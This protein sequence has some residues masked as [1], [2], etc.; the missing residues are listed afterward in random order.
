[1]D[2]RDAVLNLLDPGTTPAHTPAAFFMH[3]GPAYREGPAAIAKHL[4]Y[5]RHTGM[6]FVKI[7]YEHVFPEIAQIKT[8]ADWCKMPVYDASFYAAPLE[9]AKGLVAAVKGEAL[10]LM[11]LYS[12]FMCA[13]H[14]TSDATI[15]AHLKEDPEAVKPGLEAITESLLTFV[16]ACIDVGVD[17]F[18]AS[19]QGGEAHRFAS[20]A[21]GIFESYV[22]PHDLVLLEEIDAAC[23][24]NIL[25]V[26]DYHGG[27]DDLSP[28]L[29]YPGDVV[30]AGLQLGERTLTAR[31]VAEMFQ[32]PFM[33]GLERHGVITSGDQAAIRDR[34]RE[35]LR[36]A[37]ERFVLAADCTVP[38]DTRW[39]DLRV[40]IDAA[41]TWRR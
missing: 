1:M 18:Y 33:G 19:T 25:H 10:V 11:T 27:Y 7:Q 8:A 36:D 17:G 39:D 20:G 28:F 40:A 2:R 35:V 37:P 22:K 34:V 14:T 32:R 30:N 26:C 4:D 29:D 21:P 31:G 3:F 6:D 23:P 16:R 24:F 41:H 38:G 5:F 9:V 12:A 13:G 15:T